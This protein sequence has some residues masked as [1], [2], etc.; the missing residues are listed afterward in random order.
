[1]RWRRGGSAPVAQGMLVVGRAATAM[2]S[3]QEEHV[4]GSIGECFR[5]SGGYRRRTGGDRCAD[6]GERDPHIGPDSYQYHRFTTV[7]ACS[8]SNE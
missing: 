5:S 8:C 4:V 6:L 7:P 1:M 3:N 2:L